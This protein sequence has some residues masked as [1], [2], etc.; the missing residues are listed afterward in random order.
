MPYIVHLSGSLRAVQSVAEWLPKLG[1]Q[2][3]QFDAAESREERVEDAKSEL[4]PGL[5]QADALQSRASAGPNS[6]L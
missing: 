5:A 4:L 1:Y 3:G 6:T 2:I